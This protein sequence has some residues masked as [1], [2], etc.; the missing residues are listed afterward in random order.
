M[1][2]PRAF[3]WHIEDSTKLAF[4]KFVL[5]FRIKIE[6]MCTHKFQYKNGSRLRDIRIKSR[7]PLDGN[8][9][10]EMVGYC[11]HEF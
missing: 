11:Q 5:F 6:E 8:M 7:K 1:M 4:L 9:D 3:I 2:E 10:G